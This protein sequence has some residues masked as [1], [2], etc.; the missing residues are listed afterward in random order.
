MFSCLDNAPFEVKQESYHLPIVVAT[1]RYCMRWAIGAWRPKWM[2]YSYVHRSLV[3]AQYG[4][5]L[6]RFKDTFFLKDTYI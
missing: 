6:T 5:K 4:G 3:E 2:Y 1:S